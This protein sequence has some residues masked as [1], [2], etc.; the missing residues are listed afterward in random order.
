ME[1][2][3]KRVSINDIFDSKGRRSM[4]MMQDGTYFAYGVGM[5]NVAYNTIQLVP[6][7]IMRV[8]D[9]SKPIDKRLLKL[10]GDQKLLRIRRSSKNTGTRWY[11][12]TP[13]QTI[14]RKDSGGSLHFRIEARIYHNQYYRYAHKYTISVEA[15]VRFLK[16]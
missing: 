2:K 1:A 16:K 10:N 15:R 13:T 14:I 9:P 11:I 7:Y 8:Y 12:Y 5:F 4:S 6:T 3:I